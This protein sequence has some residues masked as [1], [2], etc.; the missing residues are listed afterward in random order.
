MNPTSRQFRSSLVSSTEPFF[1][2]AKSDDYFFHL[3]AFLAETRVPTQSS[4]K[5]GTN[6]GQRYFE[7]IAQS[8]LSEAE[9]SVARRELTEVI[10]EVH[11]GQTHSFRMKIRGIYAEPS[12]KYSWQLGDIKAKHSLH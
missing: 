3:N 9:K 6:V 4:K 10:Q 12:M 8:N 5:V 1:H 11:R 2:C 7:L